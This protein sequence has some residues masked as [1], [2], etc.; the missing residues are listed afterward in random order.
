MDLA[1]AESRSAQAAGEVPIGCVVVRDGGVIARASNRT[2]RDRDPTAHA[3]ILA[4]RRPPSAQSDWSI[5][6]SM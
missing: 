2:L 3:E 6:I 4:K 1:I 5:A